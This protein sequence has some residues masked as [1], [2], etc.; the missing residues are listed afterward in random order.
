MPTPFTHL[1]YIQDFRQDANLSEKHRTLLQEHWGAFL[2][3]SIAPDSQHMAKLRRH[4]THFFEYGAPPVRPPVSTLL[5][6]HPQLQA[7]SIVDNARRVFM[8]GYVGHLAVDEVWWNEVFYPNFSIYSRGDWQK[9]IFLAHAL[10]S[11]ID[12]RDYLS[13]RDDVYP[14]LAKTTPKLELPFIDDSAVFG[15]RD[16]IAAQLAPDGQLQTLKILGERVPQ[17]VEALTEFLQDETRLENELW[18][19]VSRT[20]LAEAEALMINHM[21]TTI[22]DYL[23]VHEG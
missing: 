9:Y 10:L 4:H 20:K 1:A 3:G 15:W 11:I 17:G 8:A 18:S 19:E 16:V 7:A 21:T 13:L 6:T 22:I 23:S 2:F 14:D 5:K 12:E